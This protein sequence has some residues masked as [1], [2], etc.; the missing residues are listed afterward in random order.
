MQILDSHPPGPHDPSTLLTSIPARLGFV[1]ERSIIVI[2]FAA[3]RT[4]NATMRH[5]LALEDDGSPSRELVIVLGGL[6]EITATYG[7]E[8]I[9][10]VIIDD[11]HPVDDHRYR[12]VLAMSDRYFGEVGG[13]AAGFAL[14]TFDAGAE[15]TT[16]W[17]PEDRA[18]SVDVSA[19][20]TGRLDD[21][22]TS[23]TAIAEAVRSGRR[24]LG[25]RSEMRSML[26]PLDGECGP[27]R[28]RPDCHQCRGRDL[29]RTG[30]DRCDPDTDDIEVSALALDLVISAMIG[31]DRAL[32]CEELDLLERAILRHDVRD[33]ALALAVTELRGAAERLWREL[34]RRLTGRGRATAATLLAHLH[35]IGGDGAYAGVAL[36]VALACADPAPLTTL[37]DS[38]LRAGVRPARLWG[39]ID[40][41]YDAARRL[42]VVIPAVTLRT[43]G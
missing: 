23:P 29:D 31:A 24:I 8:E 43:A 10:V 21:P 2:A 11:R 20:A 42:G 7:I 35:Y 30:H 38:A 26:E 1:P 36:D 15:W 13:V 6:G 17:C 37:L 16:I 40:K 32:D 18:W 14:A 19:G 27:A 33:A 39:T 25:R 5:D 3:D 41:S 9:V 34:T 22:H 12:R 28:P 4:V